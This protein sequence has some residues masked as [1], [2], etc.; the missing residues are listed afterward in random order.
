LIFVAVAFLLK[1]AEDEIKKR[2]AAIKFIMIVQV[3]LHKNGMV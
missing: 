3:L 2:A 1:G